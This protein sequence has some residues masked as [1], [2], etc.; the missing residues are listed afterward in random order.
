MAKK[1]SRVGIPSIYVD[2]TELTKKK[3]VEEKAVEK[4][5]QVNNASEPTM[6]KYQPT[7]KNKTVGQKDSDAYAKEQCK[8]FLKAFDN[9]FVNWPSLDEAKGLIENNLTASRKQ[10][11]YMIEDDLPEIEK[12]ALSMATIEGIKEAIDNNIQGLKNTYEYILE[13]EVFTKYSADIDKM[14]EVFTS[15][16]YQELFEKSGLSGEFSCAY[17]K[18]INYYNERER[19][20][21][22]F[23]E[24]RI[25]VIEMEK[26]MAHV[27]EVVKR[28]Y[29]KNDEYS[30]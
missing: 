17:E 4:K 19:L 23:E 7:Y 30:R 8:I 2:K 22:L 13:S 27:D 9:D 21:G 18:F 15:G 20:I 29:C 6:P 11:N 12:G 26:L 16:S 24:Y 10:Y 14:Y 25:S 1:N 5:E 28:V 3:N